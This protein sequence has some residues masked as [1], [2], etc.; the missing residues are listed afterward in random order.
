MTDGVNSHQ[1]NV[2]PGEPD[3]AYV[4]DG[5]KPSKRLPPLVPVP[6]MSV[7][8]GLSPPSSHYHGHVRFQ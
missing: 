4:S 1:R 3:E 8:A 2:Q 5:K 7:A 6:A